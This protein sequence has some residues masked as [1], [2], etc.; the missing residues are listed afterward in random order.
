M[1][2]SIMYVGKCINYCLLDFTML[3][4]CRKHVCEIS[5]SLCRYKPNKIFIVK[6]AR[7]KLPANADNY[8]CG[9]HALGPRTQTPRCL[10]FKNQKKLTISGLQERQNL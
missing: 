2:E 4:Y 6:L 8:T 10:P 9:V 1:N 7:E 5:V 3:L